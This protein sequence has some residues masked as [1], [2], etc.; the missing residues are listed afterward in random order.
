LHP[1]YGINQRCRKRF[2]EVFG[3]IKSSAGLAKIKLRGRDRVDAAFTLALAAYN[4][5]RSPK[6]LGAAT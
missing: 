1:G 6:L 3:W 2:E 5:V 4:L